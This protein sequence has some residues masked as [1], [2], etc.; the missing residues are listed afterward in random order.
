MTGNKYFKQKSNGSIPHYQRRPQFLSDPEL[1][2]YH[3]LTKVFDANI[4]IFA[5]VALPQL[6]A[7][8]RPKEQEV[9]HWGRVQR[10]RIEFLLCAGSN[11]EPILAVKVTA[12]FSRDVIDDVLEDIGLPLLRLKPR[13]A[14]NLEDV[15]RRINF[16]LQDSTLNGMTSQQESYVTEQTELGEEPERTSILSRSSTLRFLS[17]IKNKYHERIENLR[18]FTN[19]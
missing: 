9:S 2:A 15:T 17:G 14:Y 3:I 7:S 1:A 8:F 6:I 18:T 10:R 19:Q 12:S 11:L 5:K 16:V 4:R 13:N